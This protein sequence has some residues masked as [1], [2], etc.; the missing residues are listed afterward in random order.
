M[1]QFRRLG[2]SLDYEPR[3]LHDGRRLHRG[4][5]ALLRPPLGPRLDLPR[6]TG[7]STGARS[8]RPRSPTSRST[9]T[10]MDDTLTYARYPFADGSGHDHDRDRP[11]GDDARR[12]RGR[13]ASRRRALPRRRRQGGRSSRTSSGAVPVIADDARR[14]RVRHRRAQGHARPRSDRLRDRPR[15]RACRMLTVIGLGRADER[16][17]RRPRRADAGRRPTRR[18]SPG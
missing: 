2:A 15:P 10:T 17:R 11:P 18:S 9:T 3:A 13:G 6:R 12:R 4:G 16:G 1:A 8:T 14:A 5:D 7:S